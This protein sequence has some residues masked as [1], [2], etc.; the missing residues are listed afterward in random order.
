MEKLAMASQEHYFFSF[1]K[2]EGQPFPSLFLRA[3]FS[4]RTNAVPGHS[5]AAM[6][7]WPTDEKF[8]ESR[9]RSN[10]RGSS[11]S[12][13]FSSDADRKQPLFYL[14]NSMYIHTYASAWTA[15]QTIFF[16]LEFN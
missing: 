3:D 7:S 4:L 10:G 1:L 12:V 11:P 9:L 8:E 6:S 16:K 13:R 2:I 14:I 5:V 15:V